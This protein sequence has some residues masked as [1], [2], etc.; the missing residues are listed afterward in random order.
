MMRQSYSLYEL[1]EYIRRVISLNFSEPIWVNCEISQVKQVKGNVYLDLVYHDEKSGEITAQ[2][3]AN[4]WYKSFLFLK[5]KLGELLP[6]IL[7]EGIHVLLKVQVEFNERYGLKLSIE[8]IDP[9]YTIGQMELTRQKILQQLT[10]EGWIDKNK[11]HFM[12]DVIQKIA[13]I[14][15]SQAAGYI[16]FTKHLQSN[17]YGYKFQTTLY[18]AAMQGMNTEKEVCNALRA[19]DSASVSYDI[20]LI[21]R[22]GGSKLDLSWFDNYN[23]G[24]EIAKSKIP[25][26]T[27]IGHEIDETVADIVANLSLKTPTAVADFIIRQNEDFEG[28]IIGLTQSILQSS[29]RIIK[30]EEIL[31]H[32]TIQILALLPSEIVRKHHLQ[33]DFLFNQCFLAGKQKIQRHKNQLA[34]NEQQ[35]QLMNPNNILKKGYAIVRQNEHVISKSEYQSGIATQISFH[36][37]V[38]EIPPSKK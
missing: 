34:F 37:G 5:N 33:I 2:I 4:I 19:I 12:P 11:A 3:S 9:A 22:G 31:L 10:N 38:I 35:I 21:I 1:N 14:S 23:I 24:V 15:S 32:K 29:Q 17:V 26:I 28:K 25:V 16:D 13:I 7:K 20:I 36:D 18:E 27:G 8:D 6:S 30:H